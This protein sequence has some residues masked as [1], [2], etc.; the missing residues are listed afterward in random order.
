MNIEID[1]LRELVDL[2]KSADISELTVRDGEA[3]ITIKKRL[4]AAAAVAAEP[5]QPPALPEPGGPPAALES[6][7]SAAPPPEQPDPYVSVKASL[8]GTFHLGEK[9]GDEP[10]IRVGQR[11]ENGQVVC[12]IE[13]MKLVHEVHSPVAGT[14]VQILAEDG[15]PVEYGTELMLIETDPGGGSE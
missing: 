11:V 14:V 7:P 3:S 15:Q 13:S 2:V 6:A 1:R 12:T 4:T 5:A 9:P 8:V 10:A